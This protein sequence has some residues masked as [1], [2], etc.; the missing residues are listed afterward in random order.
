MYRVRVDGVDV[1][2]IRPNQV[3]TLEVS[4]G[5]HTLQA[6]YRPPYRVA[7][8]RRI[9]LAPGEVL[10]LVLPPGWLSSLFGLIWLRKPKERVRVR[11]KRSSRSEQ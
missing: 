4:A 2:S 1:R 3:L 7:F 10:D 11:M 5:A 6:H 8:E 9:M